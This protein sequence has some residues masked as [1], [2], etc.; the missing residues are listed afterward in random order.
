MQT[1]GGEP[2]SNL[3]RPG[4]LGRNVRAWQ[5]FPVE[6]RPPETG[7]NVGHT[8]PEVSSEKGQS[9]WRMRTIKKGQFVCCKLQHADQKKGGQN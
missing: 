8:G 6:K 1:T 7:V 2:T 3:K 5:S 4:Q 9:T